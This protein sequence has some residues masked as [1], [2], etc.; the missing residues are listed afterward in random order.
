MSEEKA[1]AGY[2]EILKPKGSFGDYPSSSFSCRESSIKAAF[3]VNRFRISIVGIT[4][5][6]GF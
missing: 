1:P 6:E 4:L 5:S 3:K 2:P